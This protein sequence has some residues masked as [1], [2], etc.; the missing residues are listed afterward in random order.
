MKPLD[1]NVELEYQQLLSTKPDYENVLKG[2][3]ERRNELISTVIFL[4]I[5][6]AMATIHVMMKDM[7]FIDT[8][9]MF[10]DFGNKLFQLMKS[11]H[12]T[13]DLS[14]K[15]TLQ[16]NE[17]KERY[18][19]VGECIYV[20]KIVEKFQAMTFYSRIVNHLSRFSHTFH[21]SPK[22]GN[23]T[24]KTAGNDLLQN[25]LEESTQILP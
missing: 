22:V 11:R 23:V 3:N 24:S 16:C 8:M 10:F 17:I 4:V 25:M 18:Q 9:R 21:F 13:A 20:T 7:E 1:N 5:I 14:K 12:E 19:S 6:I 2:L 15:V